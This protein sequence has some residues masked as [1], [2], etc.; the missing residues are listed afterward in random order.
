MNGFVGIIRFDGKPVTLGDME[1]VS[2]HSPHWVPDHRDILIEDGMGFSSVQRFLTPESGHQTMPYR[3]MDSGCILVGDIFL[4]YRDELISLLELDSH[5]SD[6]ELVM[7]AYLCFGS[8]CLAYLTGNFSFAIWDP[9]T[10]ST[11][12][13]TDHFGK[14]P[15]FYSISSDCLVFSNYMTPFRHFCPALSLNFAFL[16]S[17]LSDS[18]CTFDTCYTQVSKLPYGHYAQVSPTEMTAFRYYSLKEAVTQPQSFETH[19]ECYKA[20][21]ECFSS[22][23]QSYIPDQMVISAHISGGLDSTSVACVAAKYLK[24]RPLYGFTAIPKELVGQ[25][26]RPGWQYNEK[27]VIQSALDLYPNIQHFDYTSSPDTDIT[28]ELFHVD[29]ISDQPIRNFFNMDWIIGSFHYAKKVNSRILL[30]GMLGNGS[31]SWR[32]ISGY[33]HF[34]SFL[35]QLKRLSRPYKVVDHLT[36]LL[37]PSFLWAS[38]LKILKRSFIIDLQYFL[39]FSPYFYSRFSSMYSFQL[40]F[41]IFSADPTSDLRVVEFCYSVPQKFYCSDWFS[42]STLTHRLLV[43]HGLKGIVPDP[44]RFNPNRGEQAADWLQQ[45]NTHCSQWKEMIRTS[46]VQFPF[47]QKIYNEPQLDAVFRQIPP[48][49]PQAARPKQ[50]LVGLVIGMSLFL[51][52][53]SRFGDEKSHSSC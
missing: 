53:I 14:T 41:G 51:T 24:D 28:K 30:T 32:G 33:H 13:A 22:A 7:M 10:Q 8:D 17:F 46:M 4:T 12:L 11:F 1:A 44:V 47:L 2:F 45:F 42:G 48:D 35:S 20:F 37:K 29:L 36:P 39:L 38:F 40:W 27:E 21:Q 6:C 5:L 19:D 3:D 31:I 43:R 15:C 25:S 9:R 50:V 16:K 34:R 49:T 23:V 18:V 52:A 26:H